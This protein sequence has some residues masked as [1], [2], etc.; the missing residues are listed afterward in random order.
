MAPR[1]ASFC[2]YAGAGEGASA[3]HGLGLAIYKGLFEA[4]GGHI[5]AESAGAGR[6]ST[7]TFTVLV[8]GEPVGAAAGHAAGPPPAAGR[9]GLPRIL[10]VD[11]D[12]R[13][14]RFVR[15]ALSAAGYAPS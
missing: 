15:G 3:G 12:P 13:M 2:R 4:H 6:G 7:F 10:V 5:W 1:A 14:L 11:D 9:D 8:T